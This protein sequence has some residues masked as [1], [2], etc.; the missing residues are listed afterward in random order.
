M[1]PHKIILGLSLYDI[2]VSAG[3]VACFLLLCALADKR[4]VRRR[5]QNFSLVAGVIAVICGFGSAILF[6]AFYNIAEVGHFE[7]AV[8]TG[9]TFYGGLVGGVLVFLL[10]YFIAGHFYF[11]GELK[12]YHKKNF[13]EMTACIA[14]GITLAHSFG[15]IGCLMAGCCHGAPSDAW[16]ALPMHGNQG[17]RTYVPIQL[18]EA[19]FLLVLTV[20]LVILVLK[21]KNCGLA[22]YASTYAV[23]R[24][25]IEFFRT[26]DRGALPFGNLTPSQFI[27]LILFFAGLLLL[28]NQSTLARLLSREKGRKDEGSE[29]AR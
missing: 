18:F 19:I 14:P 12:D 20:L 9:A 28:I 10:I 22:A 5:L 17:Y 16:Y 21:G 15:R 29:E 8:N 13:F 6:Q 26:D 23:W 3:I 24:F 2:L 1:Y 25:V 27:A 11:K 4:G 7:L